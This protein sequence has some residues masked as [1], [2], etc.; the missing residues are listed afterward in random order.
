MQ[1]QKEQKSVIRQKML[2]IRSRQD[3]ASI[4]VKSR[5]IWKRLRSTVF[6]KEAKTV[7]F[8][9]SVKKEV[10]THFMIRRSMKMGKN[11]VVPFSCIKK[12]TLIPSKLE[13]FDTDL[14][15]GNFGILEPKKDKLRKVNKKIIDLVVVPGVVFDKAGSRLGFGAGYYDRFL[16]KMLLRTKFLGLAYDFQIV[17]KLPNEKHDIFMD[18]ILTDKRVIE[19]TKS[20]KKEGV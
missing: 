3:Q 10:D 1:E 14:K 9:V 6:F 15:K 18:A 13:N 7:M 5:K 16:K 20:K 19:N 12:V 8:Y 11:V 2:K 4:G 17:N